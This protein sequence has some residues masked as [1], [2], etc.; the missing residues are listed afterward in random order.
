MINF[1]QIAILM[2]LSAV[3]FPMSAQD[4][5]LVSKSGGLTVN[6]S[7]LAFDGQTYQIETDLG[8]I[9][10]SD[11]DLTCQGPGCPLAKDR[12]DVFSLISTDR[13]SRETLVEL[14]LSYAKESKKLANPKGPFLKPNTIELS[15]RTE[16]LE[17][18]IAFKSDVINLRFTANGSGTPVGFDA[19]QIISSAPELGGKI[20][21]DTLRQIWQGD[22]TNWNQLGGADQPIRF[23]LP[24]YA[25]DLYNSFTNFDP[26]MSA[27]KIT[28][29]VEYFLSPQAIIETVS[30][31]TDT[32]GLIYE[33]HPSDLTVAL[34]MGCEITSTPS[35][36]A[37]QSME[38]PLSFQLTL[39]S[40]NTFAPRTAKNLQT[41]A[42]TPIAQGV[43]A[44]AGLI[45][46]V[47]NQIDSSY[48]GKRF[49]DAISAADSDVRLSALQE[50]KTFTNTASRL[51]TT[52]YFAPNGRDLDEKST[53]V[54]DAL[55]AHLS[56]QEYQNKTILAVGFS[57]SQGGANANQSISL[58]RA[59]AVQSLF[60]DRD[61][62]S[63][64]IGFGEVAPI[65]CN[66]T[67]Y[68]RSKNRRVEIWIRD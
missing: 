60:D 36:F 62:N 35:D 59:R 11:N 24:I 56:G 6:G 66:D 61:I 67:N 47:G 53:K 55:S 49:G 38:Y 31:T 58:T 1:K 19:V 17:S 63:D 40:N 57:D 34:D 10:I 50:F 51:A 18:I 22:I 23:I 42:Q 12:L 39:N 32:I 14:L 16:G 20:G 15:H 30:Q 25:D 45:P 26:N 64:A 44:A 29:S 5:T 46:L 65:G 43:F 9:T 21:V 33:S 41:F 27:E 48:L 52:L 37:I 7:L 54:F 28:P 3:A 13:I 2:S 4:I 8:R 68:G